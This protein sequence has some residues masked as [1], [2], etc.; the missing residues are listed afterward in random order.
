MRAGYHPVNVETID[1][2]EF[3]PAASL[4]PG[5]SPTCRL[6]VRGKRNL[7]QSRPSRFP[8]TWF[9]DA[10]AAFDER[11]VYQ[12]SLRN[13]RLQRRVTSI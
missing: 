10:V 4:C 1:F 5:H 11:Q 9:F 12:R 3:E 6:V 2:L 8:F 13:L 7:P